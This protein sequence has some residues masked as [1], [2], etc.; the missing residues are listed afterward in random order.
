MSQ[1]FDPP[2]RRRWR[3]L[4]CVWLSL[5]LPCSGSRAH[6]VELDLAESS[7]ARVAMARQLLS[8][9]PAIWREAQLR[10]AAAGP[11]GLDAV[12]RARVLRSE[13]GR[14]RA[15]DVARIGLLLSV[16]Y[17]EFVRRPEWV[18]LVADSLRLA[19]VDVDSLP[20]RL[21]NNEIGGLM[22]ADLLDEAAVAREYYRPLDRVR[23]WGGFAVPAVLAR[24]RAVD[25]AERGAACAVLS[26]LGALAQAAALDSLASD[27]A[28]FDRF[29]GCN[30]G[31]VTVGVQGREHANR[32]RS[33]EYEPFR[34][35]I[36]FVAL[37][38]AWG[39]TLA[40]EL[41]NAGRAVQGAWDRPR[42]LPSPSNWDDWWDS[43]RPAWAMWWSLCG[44]SLV[45]ADTEAWH[46]WMNEAAQ[47]Q[48]RR[49][50]ARDR[51]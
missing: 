15:A 47:G 8:P 13:V 43:V 35:E 5:L 24:L 46:R 4:A 26:D 9:T 17:A 23:R 32:L 36:A 25:P 34:H 51:H 38:H 1:A 22:A 31:R 11:A 49:A 30:Y 45:P 41:S 40:S 7:S 28:T 6:A 10:L 12:V 44:E 21:M 27:P 48:H 37:A 29:Y 16:P 39:V 33:M 50:P 2:A 14:R 18:A 42:T 20:S 19:S 3:A